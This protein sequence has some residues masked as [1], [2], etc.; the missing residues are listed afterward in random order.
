M[1]KTAESKH[2]RQATLDYFTGSQFILVLILSCIFTP[3]CFYAILCSSSDMLFLQVLIR[4]I[5]QISL[6]PC[7]FLTFPH[8]LGMD[9]PRDRAVLIPFRFSDRPNPGHRNRLLCSAEFTLDAPVLHKRSRYTFAFLLLFHTSKDFMNYK[10]KAVR[11]REL[12]SPTEQPSEFLFILIHKLKLYLILTYSLICNAFFIR[13][14]P[15][16]FCS[17][18]SN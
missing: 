10:F 17:V 6:H 2:A 18:V 7:F 8:T 5:C 15:V 16:N 14:I 12:V 13:H 3:E 11:W 9:V 1:C 4:P